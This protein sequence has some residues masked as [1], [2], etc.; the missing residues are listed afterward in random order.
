MSDRKK[1]LIFVALQGLLLALIVLRAIACFDRLFDWNPVTILGWLLF[2][3]GG[4]FSLYSAMF[5]GK[6]LTP[7]PIPINN[8]QLITNGPFSV[9]RHP[10]YLG[11][12]MSAVG[13]SFMAVDTGLALLAIALFALLNVKSR[14][15]ESL[16]CFLY[17]HYADYQ[18]KVKRLIPLL[19]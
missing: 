14:F 17:P 4:L 7:L 13:L 8:H 10:I 1:G 16:L 9:V 6:L 18:K 15:E 2:C 11:L 5:M 19:F 12:V 3:V